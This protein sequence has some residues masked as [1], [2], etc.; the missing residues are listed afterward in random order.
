MARIYH[1]TQKQMDKAFPTMLENKMYI[2]DIK[3]HLDKAWVKNLAF[4]Q[5]PSRIYVAEERGDRT[6]HHLIKYS[7]EYCEM[8]GN[9]PLYGNIIFIYGP[10]TFEKVPD[11][12]KNTNP[13]SITL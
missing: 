1:L 8:W 13:L 10:K 4:G 7:K 9:Q 12:F 3:R 11:E 6:P 2:Q 5:M